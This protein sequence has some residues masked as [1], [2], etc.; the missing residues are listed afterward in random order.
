MSGIEVAGLILACLPIFIDA[1][2]RYRVGLSRVAAG[3]RKRKYVEKL[4]HALL[5]HRQTLEEIIKSV[6]L[7]SGCDD[8]FRFAENALAFLSEDVVRNEV[9]E[10]LG[11]NNN[12]AFT[13]ALQECH[14]I[15]KELA[16]SVAGLVPSIKVLS[17]L[18]R[19]GIADLF[20][21][22]STNNLLQII[23]ANEKA[24]KGQLDLLPRV[25]LMLGVDRLKE[26]VQE[27]DASTAALD[28][29]LQ[30]IS[31]N[32]QIS[33]RLPS[34]KATKLAKYL[35]K[36][37]KYADRLYLE[38]SHGWLLGCHKSHEAKLFLDD[39]VDEALNISDKKR[40]DRGLP[41]FDFRVIFAG[42]AAQTKTLWHESTVRVF[43]EDESFD[44]GPNINMPSK[45]TQ[46]T[47][48]APVQQS[49][50]Q[51]AVGAINDICSAIGLAECGKKHIVFVLTEY[52]RMAMLHPPGK[53][54]VPCKLS[55]TITLKDLLSRSPDPR[56]GPLLAWKF[57]MMLALNLASNLL[58]LL[59]TRW[60][61]SAWSKE[62]VHFILQPLTQQADISQPFVSHSFN[63]G[64]KISQPGREAEPKEALLELGIML[65]EIW[66]ETTLESRFPLTDPLVGHYMRLSLALEWLD[67]IANP[68][69]DLYDKAV[70][71]CVRRFIGGDSR[72]SKWDDMKLWKGIC[73]D[74]IEP[75]S[76]NCKQWR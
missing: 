2:H 59:Q 14:T 16:E 56:R 6:L 1:L 23:E 68:L 9:A 63:P 21:K 48:I 41:V 37:Q 22:N 34:R 61:Q 62:A 74:V 70:N 52:Q 40:K 10:Y 46:V 76:K 32:R 28:R 36:V 42:E 67:D 44:R 11:E 72:L 39:R 19:L 20:R 49:R 31:S 17:P 18:I 8:P 38:V 30:L 45:P 60:L 5:L 25:K 12:T 58:Q 26:V 29:F 43:E 27:L 15:V 66:H 65:L 54:F 75:L 4:A 64:I 33:E 47:V 69:P 57:R 55:K 35:W 73:E 51:I 3:F 53:T 50:P 13:S 71:H 24:P 7:S